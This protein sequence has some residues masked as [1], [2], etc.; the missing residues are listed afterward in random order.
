M[1]SYT[2]IPPLDRTCSIIPIKT[3]AIEAR[4]RAT[5][6]MNAVLDLDE[7]R[8]GLLSSYSDKSWDVERIPGKAIFDLAAKDVILCPY[9]VESRIAGSGF[10]LGIIDIVTF[11]FYFAL[12]QDVDLKRDP[13]CLLKINHN[14][15]VPYIDHLQVLSVLTIHH[16]KENPI[17]DAPTHNLLSLNLEAVTRAIGSDPHFTQKQ[18]QDV[19][20]EYI[21][22]DVDLLLTKSP[23]LVWVH[24]E[25]PVMDDRYLMMERRPVDGEKK[26][27]PRF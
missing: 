27:L 23:N 24:G 3:F 20:C 21:S 8:E 10:R 18:V 1:Q 11:P 12:I 6:I 19:V 13:H 14:L 2:D 4:W 15:L 26:R 17:D 16:W 25:D 9:E 7:I 22:T 5:A